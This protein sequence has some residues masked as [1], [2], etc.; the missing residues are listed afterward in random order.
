MLSPNSRALKEAEA[1][2]LAA[3]AASLAAVDDFELET[4]LVDDLEEESPL[5]VRSALAP[6]KPALAP[7][8][9]AKRA[10]SRK[11][12]TG[13]NSSDTLPPAFGDEDAMAENVG[14]LRRATHDGAMG[15]V[16]DSSSPTGVAAGAAASRKRPMPSSAPAERRKGRVKFAPGVQSPKKTR[17]EL[18]RR[19]RENEPKL[20]QLPS[21][22]A[23]PEG[24]VRRKKA[25]KHAAKR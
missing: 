13:S 22:G 6:I 24:A 11:D 18:H 15:R 9:G 5:P 25:P 2:Q 4:A 16:A 12:S 20:P 19:A 21:W 17:Q 23:L 7:R 10:S 8:A 3:L 1:A 14:S